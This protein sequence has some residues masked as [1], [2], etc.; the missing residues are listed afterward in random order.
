MR[1]C[2]SYR[3]DV[4][5]V[6]EVFCNQVDEL[7]VAIVFRYRASALRINATRYLAVFV[8]I[9]CIPFD[10]APHGIDFVESQQRR[11]CERAIANPGA[12]IRT[13]S[14]LDGRTVLV[15]EDVCEIGAQ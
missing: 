5:R 14:R 11:R 9:R 4:A 6:A 1:K 7:A 10:E 12:L 13:R 3:R 8:L 2:A 15:D